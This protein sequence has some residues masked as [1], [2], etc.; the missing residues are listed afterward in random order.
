MSVA[1]EFTTDRNKAFSG[2][3]R[4]LYSPTENEA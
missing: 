2:R 1:K 4:V 3:V